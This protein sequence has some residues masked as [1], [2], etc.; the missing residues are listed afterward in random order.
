[1][2]FRENDRRVLNQIL[3]IVQA[4]QKGDLKMSAELDALTA[5]VAQNTTIEESAVTLITGLAAQI[6]AA[7]TDP[8]KLVALTTSL[9][10]SAKDLAAAIAANTPTP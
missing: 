2:L 3:A 5:Q 7:G 9:N 6:T 4:M 8:A 1:M 10:T